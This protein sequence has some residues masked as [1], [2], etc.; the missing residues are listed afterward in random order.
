MVVLFYGIITDF[1]L[2]P[3]RFLKNTYGMPLNLF[4][5]L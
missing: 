1:I 5:C 3:G 4:T 2:R